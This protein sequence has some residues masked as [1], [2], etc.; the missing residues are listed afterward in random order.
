MCDT[1]AGY[2]G[3]KLSAVALVEGEKVRV[4]K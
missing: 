1:G 4:L 3:G 2:F